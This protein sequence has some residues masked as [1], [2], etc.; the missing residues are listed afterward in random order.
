MC[1]FEHSGANIRLCLMTGRCASFERGKVRSQPQSL[2]SCACELRAKALQPAAR[3][4]N[5]KVQSDFGGNVERALPALYGQRLVT[6]CRCDVT[7]SQVRLRDPVAVVVLE[8]ATQRAVEVA[9]RRVELSVEPLGV[10][11]PEKGTRGAKRRAEFLPDGRTHSA[12][13]RAAF[14]ISANSVLLAR[15]SARRR[16]RASSRW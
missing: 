1:A 11:E 8:A 4:P 14:Q 12:T 6:R 2:S 3:F 15:S 13:E 9:P 5:H 16:A 7:E 10:G